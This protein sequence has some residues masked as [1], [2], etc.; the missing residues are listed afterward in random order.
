[1][2]RGYNIIVKITHLLICRLSLHQPE[3]FDSGHEVNDTVCLEEI[4][5]TMA[6]L[7]NSK[8]GLVIYIHNFCSHEMSGQ[9]LYWLRRVE[10]RLATWLKNLETDLPIPI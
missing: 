3:A 6:S 10:I 4:K 2:F 5:L 8:Y 1:M 7:K 9:P